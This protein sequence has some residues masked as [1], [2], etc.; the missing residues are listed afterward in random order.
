[1]WPLAKPYK[2]WIEDISRECE[3]STAERPA[4]RIV[5]ESWDIRDRLVTAAHKAGIE[6]R[7]GL[8]LL[9]G[10]R[11][12]AMVALKYSQLLGLD[13]LDQAAPRRP[14]RPAGASWSPIRQQA[15]TRL[16]ERL[17]GA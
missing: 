9:A 10:A 2:A 14:G 4:L 17:G 12:K 7:E 11:D 6:T 5:A 1:M 8:R 16:A 15:A 3:L 13:K